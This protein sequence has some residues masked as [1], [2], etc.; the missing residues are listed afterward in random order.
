MKSQ[1]FTKEELQKSKRIYKSATPKYTLDWYVKWVASLFILCALSLRGIQGL[2]LWDLGFSAIG[3]SLWLWVSIMWQDRA[4]IV[5]NAS[6]L[7]L[8]IRTI[9]TSFNG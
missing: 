7:L 1:K 5:L 3:V 8:L 4:L 9:F 6:G 2:H